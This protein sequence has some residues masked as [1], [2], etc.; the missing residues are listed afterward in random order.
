MQQGS[1]WQVSWMY[2]QDL[3]FAEFYFD[4]PVLR[5]VMLNYTQIQL[6]QTP[7][8]KKISC[9]TKTNLLM[10]STET[11]AVYL[12]TREKH[13]NTQCG[14]TESLFCNAGDTNSNHRTWS[15]SSTHLWVCE[16]RGEQRQSSVGILSEDRRWYRALHN[17]PLSAVYLLVNFV[18]FT[19]FSIRTWIIKPLKSHVL[20]TDTINYLLSPDVIR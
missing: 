20:I 2:R 7:Q 5:G 16:P 19:D 1:Q 17:V 15:M 4:A 18:I 3:E 14:Q 9:I 10:L 8:K 11:M 6:S 13:R 12:H